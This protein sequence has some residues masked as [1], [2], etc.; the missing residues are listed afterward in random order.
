MTP[1]SETRTLRGIIHFHSRYSPD[2]VTTLGGILAIAK[3]ESLEFLLLTDHNTIRGASELAKLARAKG[4]PIEVPLAAE[5]Q[6]DHGDLIAAFI[7]R[8]IAARN[9]REFVAEVRAQ[10]GIILLPHPF[11][12]HREVELLATHADL[13]EVYNGRVGQGENE[14][15]KSL[16]A[17]LCKPGYWASDS[18]SSRSLS[19]VVV[20]V[21]DLGTLRESLLRGEIRPVRCLSCRKSD[22]LVSRAIKVI[23]TGDVNAVGRLVARLMRKLA[24]RAPT[25]SA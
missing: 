16:A 19:Q 18:H 5:Y 12:H 2:S 23:R 11:V 7:E 20:S 17:R 15:A 22:I 8:E 13:I 6:T 14:A 25:P 24:R 3:R 4:L 1:S 21:A 9:L 10:N